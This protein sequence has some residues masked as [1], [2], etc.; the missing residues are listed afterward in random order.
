MTSK[1]SGRFETFLIILFFSVSAVLLLFAT[2]VIHFKAPA[3]PPLKYGFLNSSGKL[4]ISLVYDSVGDFHHGLATVKQDGKVFVIDRQGNRTTDAPFHYQVDSLLVQHHYA[5]IRPSEADSLDHSVVLIGPIQ[6]G[7]Q[8]VRIR[9]EKKVA[10]KTTLFDFVYAF[11]D[12]Q[13]PDVK[14][15]IFEEAFPYSDSLTLVRGEYDRKWPHPSYY[16]NWTFLDRDG[17]YIARPIYSRAHSFSEGLA[18]V[19]I[20]MTPHSQM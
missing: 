20:F 16:R 2:G 7:K 19:A 13:H 9:R 12:T 10:E 1:T 3:G 5:S 14:P 18:A 17:K 11:I 4:E 6:F 8:L 15:R